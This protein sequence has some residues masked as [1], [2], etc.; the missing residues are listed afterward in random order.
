MLKCG[1]QNY[2]PPIIICVHVSLSLQKVLP[3][4]DLQFL[5]PATISTVGHQFSGGTILICLDSC[6]A[7]LRINCSSVMPKESTAASI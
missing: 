6:G 3:E 4:F 7:R 1:V 5:L 2:L